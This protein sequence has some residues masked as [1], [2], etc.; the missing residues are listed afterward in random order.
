MGL[1]KQRALEYFGHG[2][3]TPKEAFVCPDHINDYAI[4]NYI[5]KE[6]QTHVCSYC[7]KKR[8]YVLELEF[9]LKF[10]SAGLHYFYSH[11]GDEMYASNE[12]GGYYGSRTFDSEELINDEVGLMIENYDLQ[13]D[14]TNAF[15]DSI[16]W[17]LRDPYGDR[18]HEYLYYSWQHF[19]EI[20]KHQTRFYFSSSKDAHEILNHVGRRVDK[21]NLFRV[22]EKGSALY[23]G[24]QHLNSEKITEAKQMASPPKALAIH[25]NRMSPAGISMFYCSF[26]ENISRLETIDPVD[27]IR[28]RIT[29]AKFKNQEDLYLLDLTNIPALPS[30]FDPD[31]REDFSSIIFLNQFV[32]DLSKEIKRDGKEHIEYIPTQ[33]VTEYFKYAFEEYTKISVEGIIYPS[34]KNPE[35]SACVLFLNHSESLKK[36]D[37][38]N[39]SIKTGTI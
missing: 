13:V 19:K 22:L 31:R 1:A 24:R 29:T 39:S 12:E 28:T 3:K 21:L 37:F 33:V 23:R 4:K 16:T 10:I 38:D 15:D 18:E 11:A 34:S 27:K 35:K 5:K 6:G 26:D 32:S 7:G 9:L 14:I 8:K 2:L 20:V 17:C 36:L 25:S 30:I